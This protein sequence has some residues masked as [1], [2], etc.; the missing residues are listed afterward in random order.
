MQREHELVLH[1][2][3][4]ASSLG[5]TYADARF[6]LQT[7]EQICT[8]YETLLSAGI[9]EMATIG[10]R[11]LVNGAFGFA[12]AGSLRK[13]DVEAAVRKAIALAK[14]S[15]R[16]NRRHIELADEPVHVATWEAPYQVDP[17]SV[18]TERKVALLLAAEK[19]MAKVRG[20]K[21][22]GASMSFTR[23]RKFFASTQGSRIHQTFLTT[24]C[25]IEATAFDDR[26]IHQIRSWP[27]SFG[28]QYELGGWEV[29]DKWDL[30]GNAPRVAD[31]AVM[32]A[33]A[34]LCPEMTTDLIIGGSQVALQI[35]E[36]M[37]HALE[38]D[39]VFGRELNYAGSSFA[40]PDLLGNFRYGSKIVNVYADA[41]IPGALGSYKYDDEGVAGQRIELI[42]NGILT[43]YLTS[44]QTAAELKLA[45]SGGMMRAQS[46]EYTPLV[47]MTNVCLAP[48]DAGSL[49]DIIANTK[50]GI[51]LD[52][53]YSWSID[54]LRH[55]FQFGCEVGWL[56]KNGKRA[57]VVR[58]P[59]YWGITS[60]FWRKCVAIGSQPEWT[61][62]G[63]PSC[64]KGQ[65]CQDGH[66]GHGAA[67]AKF[68]NV[69]VGM[70]IPAQE[71]GGGGGGA[72]KRAMA[73]RY[74][75]FA[76]HHHG[77]AG[78]KQCCAGGAK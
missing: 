14:A 40:T 38:S 52:Q 24:G 47:R 5:A 43:G 56:I 9:D 42:Q 50:S 49:E 44:R 2:I 55:N 60:E 34:P 26:G 35:H 69:Q 76:H 8:G 23:E 22:T 15:A 17:F 21:I 33:R 73:S 48:G 54:D 78:H 10:V 30:I 6:V 74:R 41:T 61:V 36:S 53:N 11:V 75:K 65:P 20:V 46:G 12:S 71:S 29:I 39:R 13:S 70:A 4:M 66:V 77:H 3:D 25:G 68:R 27:N 58:N 57:G 51:L 28:G 32:V 45:R 16:V 72:R 59:N 18:S 64:A 37:G 1:A 7:S 19:I 31:E 62:Y 63:I 67:P